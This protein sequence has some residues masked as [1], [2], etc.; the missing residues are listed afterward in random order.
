[1][2]GYEDAPPGPGG[3]PDRRPNGQPARSGTMN[4]LHRED[5]G[6]SASDGSAHHE[7]EGRASVR[8]VSSVRHSG[9]HDARA[10]TSRYAAIGRARA[11]VTGGSPLRNRPG[12]VAIRVPS[13]RRQRT[14]VTVAA[15]SQCV[16]GMSTQP[17]RLIRDRSH[18]LRA[19]PHTG[20]L[21]LEVV[22]PGHPPRPDGA[23]GSTAGLEG[24]GEDDLRAVR[25]RRQAIDAEAAHRGMSAKLTAAETNVEVP[26]T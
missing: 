20:R 10:T 9:D 2:T 4:E 8:D 22:E 17:A 1:M 19:A 3:S 15:A 7:C 12:R 6:R 25:R 14:L 21:T 16:S 11:V 24:R 18:P 13:E 23:V 5:R 26:R